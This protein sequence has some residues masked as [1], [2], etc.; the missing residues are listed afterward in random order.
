VWE[1]LLKLLIGTLVIALLAWLAWPGTGPAARLRRGRRNR[2]RVR[3][4]DALKYLYKAEKDGTPATLEGM[5]GVIG[6]DVDAA[7]LLTAE[8]IEAGLARRGDG[9]PGLTE[10]GREYALHVVR[11][12]RL[13]E[14]YLADRTGYAEID[15]HREAEI[16]E[17]DLS[18]EE[19]DRLQDSLGHP[20]HDPHGDPIPNTTEEA[21]SD[22]GCSLA[23]APL[24]RPLRILHVEDEPEALYRQI[25]AADLHPGT[26]V[27]IEQ[28]TPTAVVLR[29][30][31]RARALPP[32][33]AGNVE[34]VITEEPPRLATETRRTLGE[35][36]VGEEAVL[37]GIAPSVRGL[38]RR[39]LL[40]LGF[41][42]GTAVVAEMAG[43]G[44]DPIAYRV[45]GALVALRH[46]QAVQIYVA[47][48]ERVAAP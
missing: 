42:T 18:E 34:V 17:H 13:W 24:R 28:R 9:G 12:H 15:W 6:I 36:A 14:R 37:A 7:S 26:I 4:E 29:A 25:L 10:P 21:L 11:A 47:S 8:L 39:R 35:L 40:D 23:E 31:G 19:V 1:P 2:R 41:L 38:E 27:R 48:E 3:R 46:S 22:R 16:K 30:G 43:A 32:L 20:T 44:G 5:A 45:R 33:A